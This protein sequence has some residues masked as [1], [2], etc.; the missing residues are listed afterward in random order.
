MNIIREV[1]MDGRKHPPATTCF[2]TITITSK[3]LS[4]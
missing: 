1:W 4:S 3:I 2:S